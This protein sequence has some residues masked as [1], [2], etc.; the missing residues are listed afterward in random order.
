[1]KIHQA[2]KE[3]ITKIL[4]NLS[5]YEKLY[6]KGDWSLENVRHAFKYWEKMYNEEKE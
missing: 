3:L 5:E 2:T 1:M 4:W 6:C